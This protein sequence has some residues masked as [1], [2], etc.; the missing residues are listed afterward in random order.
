MLTT[1][2]IEAAKRRTNYGHP[3]NEVYHPHEDCI[4]LAYDW[5][6]AKPKL[7]HIN[8]RNGVW[9]Y[10]IEAW[11]GRYISQS[12]VEVAAE[13]HP[14]VFGVYPYFNVGGRRN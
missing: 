1:E 2:Q 6:D 14:E 8:R 9:K 7:K 11:A 10:I 12:D 3:P 5:L 4:R 13:L